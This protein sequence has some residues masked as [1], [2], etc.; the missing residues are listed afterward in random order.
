MRRDKTDFYTYIYMDT[1]KPGIF[2][3]GEFQ[4]DFEPFYVGKGIEKQWLVHLVKANRKTTYKSYKINKIRKIQKL[5]LEPKIIKYQENLTEK[6]AFDSEKK[7]IKA[8]GRFDLK[9]GPLTNL[10]DGGEG[11]SGFVPCTKGRTKENHPGVARQAEKLRGRTKET[12]PGIARQAEKMRGRTKKTHPDIARRAEK[13]K[14]RTKKTHQGVAS[15]AKKML[16][17]EC[18]AKIWNLVFPDGSKRIIKNLAKFCRE[19]DFKKG[20]DFKIGE[21][22]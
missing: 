2:V 12:H 15:H 21:I 7:L 16:G 9:K 3:Y 13:T 1:R 20:R 10:T 4:F 17:S 22:Y 18:G 11:Q 6:E 19:T 14:G 5:G 8:I